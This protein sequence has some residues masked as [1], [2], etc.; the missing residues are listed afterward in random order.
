MK[1]AMTRRRGDGSFGIATERVP[2]DRLVLLV[3]TIERYL[4]VGRSA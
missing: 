3:A 2:R 4:V 1:D